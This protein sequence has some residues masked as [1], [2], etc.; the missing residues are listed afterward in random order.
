[1]K[2]F[3]YEVFFRDHSY[4]RQFLGYLIYNKTDDVIESFI[5]G[6]TQ[7]QAHERC[8][9]I[10][11]LLAQSNEDII[12]WRNWPLVLGEEDIIEDIILQKIKEKE[13]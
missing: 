2:Y 1:M 6:R 12:V 4:H 5:K 3:A 8:K 9:L 7:R 13:I 11:E 10:M